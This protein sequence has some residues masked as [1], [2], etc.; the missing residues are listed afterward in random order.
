MIN[1]E[2]LS[3]QPK[4]SPKDGFEF[5][6]QYQEYRRDALYKGDVDDGVL[7]FTQLMGWERELENLDK[8]KI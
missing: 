6:G 4:W 1:R 8:V 3:S 5:T 2:D 7:L